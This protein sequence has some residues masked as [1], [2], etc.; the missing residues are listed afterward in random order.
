MPAPL[1]LVTCDRRDRGPTGAPSARVRPARAEVF[2]K[3]AL[4][5]AV[6]RAGGT[7][8]LLPPGPVDPASLDHLLGVVQAVVV[9]GGSFD[10]HPSH[11]GQAVA[12]RLD[13]V[14]PDRTDIELALCRA[15]LASGLPV[16]GVCGGMQALVVASGG[17]LLQDIATALPSALDHEQATDPAGPDHEVLLSPGRL[18]ALLGPRVQVNSTHHQAVDDPGALRICGRAPD[19]VVEAVEAS[20]HPFAVGVQWH[21]ELLDD[22]RLF[23]ALVLAAR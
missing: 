10:I 6:R 7:P 1:V 11:Y 22:D 2:V 3:E 19:G 21:P 8:L 18:A 5:S 4:V 13:R 16:L 14:E 20:D 17:T 15:T 23:R 12:A 9:S